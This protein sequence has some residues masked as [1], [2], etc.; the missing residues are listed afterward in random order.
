MASVAKPPPPVREKVADLGQNLE[1]WRVHID[2]IKEQAKNARVMD[3]R[4]FDRL[5]AN[6]GHGG[7]LEQLPFC[8]LRDGIIEMVSEIGRASCRERV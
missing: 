4:T 8:A 5:A 1:L 7:R 2:E 3:P 6:I